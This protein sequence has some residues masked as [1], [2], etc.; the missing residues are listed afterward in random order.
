MKLSKSEKKVITS[1]FAILVLFLS[2]NTIANLGKN[3]INHYGIE[4][5]SASK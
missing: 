2:I 3:T 4:Y 1:G 5:V